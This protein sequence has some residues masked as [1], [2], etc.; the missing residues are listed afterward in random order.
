MRK[1]VLFT[2]FLL[3]LLWIT[4]CSEEG[5]D[6]NVND[7]Q[8][9]EFIDKHIDMDLIE[10]FG[11][12]NIHFG[13]TPPNLNDVSFKVETMD[14][15][16]CTRY[17]FNIVPDQPPIL[18]HADPPTFDGSRNY[19]HFSNHT[20][21][22]A[23]HKLKTIN[24]YNNVFI[25]ENDTVYVIGD[26]SSNY[27]TAYYEEEIQ[28]EGSGHPTNGVLISGFLVYDDQDQFIGIKDYRIGKKI[29]RYKERPTPN[30]HGIIEAFAEGTIEIKTHAGMAP[31]EKWDR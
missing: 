1:T 20:E 15:V 5:I 14:Y 31:A 25:R 4:S 29:L 10:A 13:H 17:I 16:I 6:I 18:S 11:E 30:Q 7:P 2:S 21:N 9:V 28:E 23:S 22:L 8:Y 26:A 24:P 3:S 27:F 12:E 19:H